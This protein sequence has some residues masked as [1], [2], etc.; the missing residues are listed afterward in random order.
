MPQ[1][2]CNSIV[3]ARGLLALIRSGETVEG[4]RSL[5][6]ASPER[7]PVLL[8]FD[9]LAQKIPKCPEKMRRLRLR[10]HANGSPAGPALRAE[11]TK[12]LYLNMSQPKICAR[13]K[14]SRPLVECIARETGAVYRKIGRGRKFTQQFL[15][16]IRQAVRNGDRAV[17]IQHQFRVSLDF[18]RGL[19]KEIGD[20]EDRRFRRGYNVQ[21][22]KR[23]LD[24]GDPLGEIENKFGICHA[25]LW[26]LRRARGDFED[27]RHRNRRLFSDA[28]RS[29][30]F[31][32]IRD[33]HS[34]R[35]IAK[36]YRTHTDRVRGLEAEAGL[37]RPYR[38]LT[39]AAQ[40]FERETGGDA[41]TK[42]FR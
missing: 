10:M 7:R 25:T 15:K 18:I 29:G 40:K 30:I 37:R 6:G 11:I 16:R 1:E 23:A 20:Y 4:I 39:P 32:D 28:E 41:Q 17:D 5:I 24:A 14:V 2:T 22:V 33:G 27:R 26:E 19:R 3:E 38:R 8:A 31:A 13:L 42:E 36:K 34:Q 35:S 12:L 21:A 9:L